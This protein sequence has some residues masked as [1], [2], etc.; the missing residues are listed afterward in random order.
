MAK[1]LHF[2]ADAG[3]LHAGNAVLLGRLNS[4]QKRPF[5]LDVANALWG[6]KGYP[7]RQ[8]FL[9]LARD[10]YRAGLSELDFRGNPEAARKFINTW[11]EK[12]TQDKIKDLMPNGSIDG[13]TRLVLTNAIYFKGDWQSKFNKKAT[14][15]QKFSTGT[16]NS[17][18][19]PMMNQTTNRFGY[20]AGKSF[21]ALEMPYQGKGLSMVVLLPN[22]ADGLAAFEKTLTID[23]L[24]RWLGGLGKSTKVQVALP[25]FKMTRAVKL[26]QVLA[27]M[28]MP[29]AFDPQRADLSGINGSKNLYISGVYHQAFVDVNE[30]GTEAAAATGVSARTLSRPRVTTFVADHPFVFLIRDLRSGAILFLGRVA[31]P[32]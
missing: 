23:N 27:A 26:N 9:T 30:E 28:G 14:R 18:K 15:P 22:E 32:R 25:K 19:V 16:G 8:P 4:G 10:R 5:Q 31:D 24:N 29:R 3:K 20:Y 11:V 17:V 13:L 7:F 1:T 12:K 2:P 21:Q 6:Q